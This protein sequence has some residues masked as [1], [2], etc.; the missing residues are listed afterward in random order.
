[1]RIQKITT[2]RGAVGRALQV[3][4]MVEVA[5]NS[6]HSYGRPGVDPLLDV[7]QRDVGHGRPCQGGERLVVY[8]AVLAQGGGL[9]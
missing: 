4:L 2:R 5:F 1:M 6:T 3:M 9:G 7:P 8:L